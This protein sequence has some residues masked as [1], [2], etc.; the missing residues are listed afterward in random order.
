MHW[1]GYRLFQCEDCGT[2]GVDPA[3]TPEELHT[4][5]QD[6][7]STHMVRASA[8]L[9][10]V[11]VSMD[12]YLTLYGQVCGGAPRRLLDLGGGVGYWTAAAQ[13]RGVEACLMDYAEDAQAFARESMGVRWTM[14]GDICRSADYFAPETFDFVLARHSIEH[15]LDPHSYVA[16][17]ARVLRPGG[18]LQIETPNTQSLEQ[19]AH[20]M[21]TAESYKIIRRSNSEMSGRKAAELSILKSVS[22]VA[23]PKHLWGFTE[24]GM[25]RLL[26]T[27]GLEVKKVQKAEAGHPFLD[28][29]YYEA[30]P[31]SGRR[32]VGAL[33]YFWERATAPLFRGHGQHLCVT[34]V[35]Q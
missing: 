13:A 30:H 10:R 15:I 3:P 29:L 21:V 8:R 35:R 4:F 6:A 28:P 12:Y 34:A 24:S 33:Y 1:N 17:I 23:P 14:V 22:G 26:E 31:L 16:N 20:F 27:Y 25:K 7:N 19:F 32:P 9:K 18:M 5:Y 2:Q 11:G